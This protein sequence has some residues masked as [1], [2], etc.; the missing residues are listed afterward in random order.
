[1]NSGN[2]NT[3]SL[4]VD[5]AF[6]V[7][8]EDNTVITVTPGSVG[9]PLFNGDGKVTLTFNNGVKTVVNVKAE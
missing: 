4:P 2:G 8:A 9:T 3:L 6:A 5:T 7:S 1:M